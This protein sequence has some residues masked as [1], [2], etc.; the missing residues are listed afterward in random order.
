MFER[1]IGNVERVFRFFFGLLFAGWVFL[2]PHLNAIEWFVIIVSLMLIL[3]GI[4]S[5]CYFWYLLEI[6]TCASGDKDCIENS[7]C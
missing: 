4:F 5:R 3:N 1:N 7:P 2:Q 6:N